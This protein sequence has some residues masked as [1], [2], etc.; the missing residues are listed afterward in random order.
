MKFKWLILL[1]MLGVSVVGGCALGQKLGV[2]FAEEWAVQSSADIRT[3]Y[4]AM[5]EE[6]MERLEGEEGLAV[7]RKMTGFTSDGV[8]V[9]Q[10][11]EWNLVLVN[12]WNALEDG[13]VPELT[14]V[15]SGHKVD[16]RIADALL[17]MIEGAKNAGYRI[18]I[19]S[20]YRDMDKQ[21]DLFNA[22]VK[23]WLYEGL[24][25]EEA[26]AKAGTIVAYPGT[27]EHHLGLAVDLVSSEHVRLDQDAEKTKGYQWLVA[28]CHEYGFILR[29]PNN[30]TDVTGIIYEPWHFRYVG[31]E[32]AAEIME[33][34]ITLEE[35]LSQLAEE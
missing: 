20:S 28:H 10:P 24:E 2:V 13:Y 29:Y 12:K 1:G 26:E 25:Q 23:E 34:G 15:G 14:N 9:E 3:H 16:S 31:E 30:T 27:S 5:I 19:L 35:Y 21:V 33:A 6:N 11:E 32:A 8:I 18:Y 22:E 7:Y 17:D 4:Q